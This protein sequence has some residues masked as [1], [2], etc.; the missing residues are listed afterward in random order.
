[1]ELFD[2]LLD[3]VIMHRYLGYD[4]LVTAGLKC[5]AFYSERRLRPTQYYSSLTTNRNNNNT[6]TTTTGGRLYTK[7]RKK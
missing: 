4:G 2:F 7:T 1:M 6:T 3:V 5:D